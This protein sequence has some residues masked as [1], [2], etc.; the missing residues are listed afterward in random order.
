MGSGGASIDPVSATIG[1]IGDVTSGFVNRKSQEEADDRNWRHTVQMWNMNNE[2][3]SPVNQM[4]RLQE[5]G[6][7]PNLMYGQISAGNASQ[8]SIPQSGAAR[9]N[10]DLSRYLFRKEKEKSDE[11][12]DYLA[13]NNRILKLKEEALAHDLAISRRLGISTKSPWYAQYLFGKLRDAEDYFN[14]SGTIGN[15]VTTGLGEKIYD[16][17]HPKETLSRIRSDYNDLIYRN[18]PYVNGFNF[19][20]RR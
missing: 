6:L 10:L 15:K 13:T 17:F 7:N 16:S 2:Y 1:A 8:P 12:L 9:F 4:K 5:A 3:N 19:I 18:N 14:K 11:E 20:P